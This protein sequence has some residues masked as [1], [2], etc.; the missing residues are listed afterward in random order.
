MMMTTRMFMGPLYPPTTGA[1]QPRRAGRGCRA[2]GSGDRLLGCL[3]AAGEALLDRIR[4]TTPERGSRG[5][6][7][8]G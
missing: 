7:L 1:R 2:A 8:V 4:D 5:S 6:C 3:S